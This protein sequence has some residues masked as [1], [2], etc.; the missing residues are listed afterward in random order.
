MNT[1]NAVRAAHRASGAVYI[2]L[3]WSNALAGGWAGVN[4]RNSSQLF[5]RLTN[6]EVNNI[7]VLDVSAGGNG[8]MQNVVAS[9]GTP[10]NAGTTSC[11]G[12]PVISAEVTIAMRYFTSGYERNWSWC[13]SQRFAANALCTPTNLVYSDLTRRMNPVF[14]NNTMHG[15][16][17]DG[18]QQYLP[19]RAMG[20][21]HFM[22]PWTP[23]G[24][25]TR[26]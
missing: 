3:E 15:L 4:P 7:K 18:E 2:D 9:G 21:I 12:S 23:L 16:S 19:R 6:F 14:L 11:I 17:T 13:N 22:I 26:W 24:G 8:S 1:N 10:C 25:K 5:T 20:N